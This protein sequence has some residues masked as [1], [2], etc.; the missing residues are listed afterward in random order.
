MT[1]IIYI[2]VFIKND[3]NIKEHKTYEFNLDSKIIDVKN[4]ILK[5]TF[6]NKYNFIELENITEKIYKDYGKLFFDKG[7]LP[8]TI[9]NYKI[10]QF[11]NEGRV[12]SF[13]ANS[14]NKEHNITKKNN[15]NGFLKK[16]YKEDNNTSFVY[17]D[18]DFPPL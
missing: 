2:K 4:T 5:E 16:L 10:S 8:S 14:Y 12:F 18:S 3:E 1:N 7:I 17:D 15:N 11:T 9:D 6:D 13:I